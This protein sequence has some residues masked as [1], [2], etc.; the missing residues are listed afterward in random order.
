MKSPADDHVMGRDPLY[1][2]G[3]YLSNRNAMGFS[4][5]PH[6]MGQ[7][8]NRWRGSEILDIFQALF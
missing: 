5:G 8:W 6:V 3:P 4:T 1:P 7:N 2:A